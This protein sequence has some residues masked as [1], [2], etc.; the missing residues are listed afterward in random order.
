MERII[1]NMK[2]DGIDV[3]KIKESCEAVFTY[4]VKKNFSLKEAAALITAMGHICSKMTKNDPLREVQ[5]FD[6][7]S[8]IEDSFELRAASKTKS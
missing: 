7:S 1:H 4:M 2:C 5:M 8:C 3:Q 6:Y